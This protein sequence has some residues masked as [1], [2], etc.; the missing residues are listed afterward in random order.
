MGLKKKKRPMN[1]LP[2]RDSLWMEVHT[3]TECG[4]V[5]KDIPCKW[6]PQ[7]DGAT[8]IY[9]TNRPKHKD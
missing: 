1:M 3:Q 9:Q 6:K 7:K 8:I 2:R 5:E 4:G